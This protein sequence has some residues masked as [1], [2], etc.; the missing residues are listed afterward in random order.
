MSVKTMEKNFMIVHFT[1][2][3]VRVLPTT[4]LQN[5]KSCFFPKNLTEKTVDVAVK[6]RLKPL[7]NWPV[8]DILKIVGKYGKFYKNP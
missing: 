4:W 3:G 5:E 7:K 6:K 1:D 2:N 8:F